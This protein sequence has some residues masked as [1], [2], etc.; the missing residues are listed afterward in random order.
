MWCSRY[1]NTWTTKPF[2]YGDFSEHGLNWLLD[3]VF[4]AA[5]IKIVSSEI[6]STEYSDHL[7][8]LVTFEITA[9]GL[10]SA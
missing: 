6:I 9:N 7:P 4:A 2:D 8:I 1:K 10:I 3:Y 5:D